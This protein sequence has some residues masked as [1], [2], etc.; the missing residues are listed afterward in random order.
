MGWG[1]DDG[2]MMKWGW[3]EDKIRRMWGWSD[4]DMWMKLWGNEDEVEG[5]RN[6]NFEKIR[7]KGRV[8]MS[9]CMNMKWWANE[10][11][12]IRKYQ[13]EIRIAMMVIRE[14]D[15]PPPSQDLAHPLCSAPHYLLL[16]HFNISTR[17]CICICLFICICL[18]VLFLLLHSH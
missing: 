11:E 12:M 16:L 9:V 4:N 14:G 18:V 5:K 13:E 7:K 10:D 3:K 6:E 2:M 1:Y 15:W 8:E 17:I